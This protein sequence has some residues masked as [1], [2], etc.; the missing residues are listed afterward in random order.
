[1]ADVEWEPA[2]EAPADARMLEAAIRRLVGP[3]TRVKMTRVGDA[4]R[5]RA[6]APAA[7]CVR[8]AGSATRDVSA[9]VAELLVDAGVPAAPFPR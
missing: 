1:M 7:Y 5:V 9:S 8:G 4:W 3:G 6:L 2:Q